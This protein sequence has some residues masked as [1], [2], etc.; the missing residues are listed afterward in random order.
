MFDA[1]QLSLWGRAELTGDGA[2]GSYRLETRA[3][4]IDNPARGWSDWKPVDPGT[5]ALGQAAE[6]VR[7]RYVQWRLTIQG[8]ARVLEVALNYLPANAAPEIDEILVAPGTRVN[9]GATQ[10][11]YPQQTTLNFASQGGAAVN[12]DGNSAAAPLSAIRDK[13]A[14]TVRWAAHDDNGDE[15][16]FAV[17]YRRP[18]ELSWR[19]LK[20]NLTDRYL[21]FEANLLPDGP[22]RIRVVATDAPSHAAG[23]ALTGERTSDLFLLATATPQVTGLSMRPG[24][25]GLHVTATATGNRVPIARAEYSLDAGPWQY[26]EPIGRISDATRE[27][28]DFAVPVAPGAG[29]GGHVL[30][31]RAFDRYDNEGSAKVSLP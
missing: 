13:S 6:Q 18:E 7:A 12:I 17:Y 16:R 2:G 24:G 28:Y 10:V 8:A 5:Q 23:Q 3:G 29:A 20:D 26:V 1:T 19:L 30:T 11:S 14:V 9:A 21:S 15:L 22:Y 25:A 4:N 27:Q 31:L